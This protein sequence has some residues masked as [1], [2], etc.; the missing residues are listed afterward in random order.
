MTQRKAETMENH[1][2]KKSFSF[3]LFPSSFFAIKNG[4]EKDSVIRTNQG[5]LKGVIIS[6]PLL[7][8][9]PD[10][11]KKLLIKSPA[12]TMVAME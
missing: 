11:K 10:L 2:T 6:F 9:L 8:Y 5:K 1:L 7:K 3:L 4:K 12:I